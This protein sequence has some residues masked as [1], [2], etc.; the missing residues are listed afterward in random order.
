M[1]LKAEGNPGN[2]QQM[3]NGPVCWRG[4]GFKFA[5]S[6]VHLS[7]L[8][9]P[10]GKEVCTSGH[11]DFVLIVTEKKPPLV[12]CYYINLQELKGGLVMTKLNLLPSF[13]FFFP[14]FLP[15]SLNMYS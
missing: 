10:L 4:L 3:P 7:Q 1:V 5:G 11:L 6:A 15:P 12:E 14:S 9:T 13:P 2:R 8:T